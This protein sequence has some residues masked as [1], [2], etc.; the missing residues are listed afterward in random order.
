MILCADFGCAAALVSCGFEITGMDRSDPKR[1]NF[2][3]E[4]TDQIEQAALEY[5]NSRLRVTARQYFDN[6]KMLKSQIYTL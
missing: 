5:Y 3:F 4:R 1:V 6:M 2:Q